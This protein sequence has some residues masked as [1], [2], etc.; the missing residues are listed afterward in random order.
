MTPWGFYILT[1]SPSI[2]ESNLLSHPPESPAYIHLFFLLLPYAR[3]AYDMSSKNLVRILSGQIRI[4]RLT[5]THHLIWFQNNPQKAKDPTRKEVTKL[6]IVM[7]SRFVQRMKQDRPKR[8]T[9]SGI[10][11]FLRFVQ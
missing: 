6:G 7:L 9:E 1:G 10:V 2:S 5:L 11:M 3:F 4:L 8:M